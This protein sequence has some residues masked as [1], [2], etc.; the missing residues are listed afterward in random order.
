MARKLLKPLFTVPGVNFSAEDPYIWSQGER[1]WAIVNDH[2]GAFNGLG[3]DSLSLFTSQNGLDWEVAPHPLV[4]S[5]ELVWANGSSQKLNRLE[6]PQLW[7]ENGKPTVLFCAA[8]ET[9]LQL[10]SFNVH[11]P[12]NQ[13]VPE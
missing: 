13:M 1:C 2:H 7:M 3:T 11:I 12:L 4:T 5:R 6:R 10:H 8:E 9:A